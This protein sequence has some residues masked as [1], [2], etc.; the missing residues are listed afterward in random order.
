MGAESIEEN[1]DRKCRRGKEEGRIEL[2]KNKSKKEKEIR[3]QSKTEESWERKKKMLAS[4]THQ[5]LYTQTSKFEF[6]FYSFLLRCYTFFKISIRLISPDE[7]F[8]RT[9]KA[10]I[11]FVL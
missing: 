4:T 2:R 10:S 8:R 3:A 6:F 7:I 5:N 1:V 11:N 9:L